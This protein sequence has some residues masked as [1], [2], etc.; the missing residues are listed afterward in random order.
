VTADR[1]V[2]PFETTGR[3]DR[4]AKWRSPGTGLRERLFPFHHSRS[5]D[6]GYDCTMPLSHAPVA[7]LMMTGHQAAK[8]GLSRFTCPR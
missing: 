8:S 5:G 2:S 4:F 3:L 6:G 7:A 1:F